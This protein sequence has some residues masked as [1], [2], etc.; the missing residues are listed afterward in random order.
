MNRLPC[1]DVSLVEAVC[2][3][4]GDTSE[5]LTGPEIGSI[6]ADMQVED[7]SPGLTKWKRLFNA[8]AHQQNK[9]QVGNHLV[10]FVNR[11]MKPARFVQQP[12]KF[13]RMRDGLNVAMS[14]AGYAVNEQG[15]VV[16]TTRETTVSG[17]L[18]RAKHLADTLHARGTHPQVF[19]YC[20][21]ELLA[22]NYFHAVLEAVKGVAERLRQMSGLTNDG[23]ELVN[24][25]LSTK[26]PIIA[27]NGLKTETELS[28]Q[29]GFANLLVGVFGAIRNPTAHAPKVVWPMPEQ[30]ALDIFALISYVHRKLDLASKV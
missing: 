26:A 23:A 10:M 15:Q 5:G 22:E 9:H 4:L 12:E 3:V 11:A 6:L 24:Q 19:V 29:K 7:P 21:A 18:A 2:R 16:H 28:E 20:T 30:D 17:A 1:F 8:L 14:L 13:R 25:A 27:I